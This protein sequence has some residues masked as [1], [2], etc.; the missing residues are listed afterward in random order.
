MVLKAT[1]GMRS[2]TGVPTSY[3]SPP[4]DLVLGSAFS[5]SG[6]KRHGLPEKGTGEAFG[7]GHQHPSRE[8]LE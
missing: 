5:R 7:T 3:F 8:Q 4:T 2:V 1:E 6:A